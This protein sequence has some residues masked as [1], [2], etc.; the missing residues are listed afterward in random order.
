MADDR[1]NDPPAA[2]RA[3]QGHYARAAPEASSPPGLRPRRDPRRAY[4]TIEC[5]PRHHP[6]PLDQPAGAAP[7]GL[8]AQKKT[9]VAA[10]R[11]RSQRVAFALQHTS[12]DASQSVVSDEFGSNRDL[13]PTHACSAIG[14]RAVASV[15]GTTPLTTTTIA[16][17]TQQG[18]GPALMLAGGVDRLRF[19]TS[20]E[21]VLAAT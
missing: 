17:L 7:L 9:V 20:L 14:V 12:L 10:E 6:Q 13:T 8:V 19:T 15:R 1:R 18:M 16:S 4:G 2:P 21:Q 3:S 5:R 11:D